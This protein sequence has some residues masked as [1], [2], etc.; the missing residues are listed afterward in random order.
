M[1]SPQAPIGKGELYR[2]GI[3]TIGSCFFAVM[4]RRTADLTGSQKPK[5]INEVTTFAQQTSSPNLGVLCPMIG[6]NETGIDGVNESLWITFRL[7]LFLEGL[8]QWCKAAIKSY[9]QEWVFCRL[10]I[11]LNGYQFFPIQ[12]QG[13]FDKDCL[14]IF[15]GLANQLSMGVVPCGD[16]YEVG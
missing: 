3:H 6:W 9:H 5:Q 4:D 14:L 2:K 13:F 11:F 12:A 7:Q 8:D 15:Q 10:V 1:N 16:G